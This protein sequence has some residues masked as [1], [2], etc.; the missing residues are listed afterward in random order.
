MPITIETI[1]SNVKVVDRTAGLDDETLQQIVALVRAQL[2]RD[3]RAARQAESEG[4]I[5]DRMSEHDR[6]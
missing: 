5:R 4:E 2:E 1:T 3:Q 6:F